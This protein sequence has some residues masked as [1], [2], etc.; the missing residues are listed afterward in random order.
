[1]Q[2]KGKE[3]RF[4]ITEILI[5]I[6]GLACVAYGVL[7]GN[8]MPLFFGVCI[9]LGS[10]ALHFVRKKDWDAPVLADRGA[11][12]VAA[13]EV[14]RVMW[15]HAG[16]DRSAKGLEEGLRLLGEIENRLPIGATEEANMID[17]ARLITRAA[18]ARKESRG[19]H[20]RSDFPHAVRKWRN[21]H[22]EFQE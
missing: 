16:I 2:E 17:T 1:M 4:P 20:F 7:Q 14:R 8:V 12:Q 11:A 9:V 21:K 6:V 15:D 13:D 3:K 18:L 10:V 22:I 5:A 19:G